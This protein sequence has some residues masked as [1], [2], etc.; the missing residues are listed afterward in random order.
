MARKLPNML[1]KDVVVLGAGQNGLLLTHLLANMGARHVVALDMMENR[2]KVAR[3]MKATHTVKVGETDEETLAKVKEIL[4]DGP[5]FI[6]EMVG[7][8]D[9]TLCLCLDMVKEGG[10][11]YGF[12]V[13]SKE[14]YD[15]FPFNK[16]FR[17]NLKLVMFFC[18]THV[19]MYVFGVYVC[20]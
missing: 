7:H 15:N 18:C 9:K 2:L 14:G 19:C 20:L 16:I 17:R 13:P 5:D 11:V 10:S 6:F 3:E 1:F 12:G 8:Q 4:P